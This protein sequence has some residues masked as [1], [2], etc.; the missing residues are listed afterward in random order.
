VKLIDYDL[1]HV[2][3][4]GDFQPT[5]TIFEKQDNY[6]EVVLDKNN[7]AK[8]IIYKALPRI[9]YERIFFCQTANDMWKSLLNFHQEKCQAKE[10]F[11]Y[12]IVE[13][14]SIVD[15]YLVKMS[16]SATSSNFVC[17]GNN[18]ENPMSY[19]KSKQEECIKSAIEKEH[20][21]DDYYSSESE[22]EEYA[23]VVKEFK[24]IIKKQ[25]KAQDK[26][27]T[28]QRRKSSDEDETMKHK[29]FVAQ[30]PNEVCLGVDLEPDEW[31]K[32]S[33]CSRHMTGNRKLFSTYKAYNGG[34]VVF[35]SDRRGNIIGKGT[36]SQDSLTIENVEHVDNLTYNLLSIGQIC[37]NKCR[38]TFT[39]KDSEI[40]KDKKVIGRGIRKGGIYVMKLG[41]KP[42]DRIC[43][44]TIDENST[45]WH[46][47]LGHANMQQIQS[48][49]SKELVRNF[50]SLRYD[51]NFCDACKIGKQ[52]H[53]SHKAKNMLSTTR[54][55]ELLHMDLFGPSAVRSYGGN[56]YTFFTTYTH[57]Y[58]YTTSH[59]F[60]TPI[61]QH[62]YFFTTS[63]HNY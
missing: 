62:Y 58:Y 26:R 57:H 25:L 33:G 39:D 18:G 42:E 27:K 48:L 29:C 51:Q 5:K 11:V 53:A 8:M 17:E 40:I 63:I 34:N 6:F 56:R 4:I 12:K 59:N 19:N 44:A 43:L 35:G 3:S 41:D 60:T 22:D 37:D 20:N 9:E 15:K 38:V 23:K 28:T 21:Y 30:A 46:T 61:S 49:A 16:T 10:N 1:W 13:N 50:P 24:K 45:L 14:E 54:C 2:I 31:I 55:L 36:I 7:I 32:D 52:A 47:R